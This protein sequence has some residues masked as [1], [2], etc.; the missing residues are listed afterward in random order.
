[1][2]GERVKDFKAAVKAARRRANIELRS[3]ALGSA[4]PTEPRTGF[5]THDLRHRRCTMWLAQGSSPA[6]VKEA[7]GHADLKT[8]MGYMHLV[9]EQL[10]D[11]V[12]PDAGQKPAIAAHE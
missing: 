8:T 10:I 12:E 2:A 1:M 6:K 7:M 3:A 5:V 11:L 9:R 4:I